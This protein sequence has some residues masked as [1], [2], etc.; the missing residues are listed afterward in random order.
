MATGLRGSSMTVEIETS[1]DTYTEIAN[2]TSYDRQST[3]SVS[4]VPV[5][6]D[7]ETIKTKGPRST[8][9][10][11]EFIRKIGD[12]GQDAFLA[13]LNADPEENVTLRIMYDET[14]GYIQEFQINDN[15]ENS[16][17]AEFQRVTFTLSP[18]GVKTEVASS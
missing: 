3:R 14:N 10:S 17:P 13:A 18:E 15:G 7:T 1:P 8:T 11:L 4:E 12:A 5:F 16:D 6:G 9:V 2:G